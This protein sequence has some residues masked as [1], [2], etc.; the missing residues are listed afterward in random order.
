MGALKCRVFGGRNPRVPHTPPPCPF[1]CQGRESG[2]A[3]RQQNRCIAASATYPPLPLRFRGGQNIWATTGVLALGCAGSSSPPAP[4]QLRWRGET[5]AVRG[6]VPMRRKPRWLGCSVRPLSRSGRG[7]Q[8][9]EDQQRIRTP[10]RTRST[11]MSQPGAIGFEMGSC[12]S[13]TRNF[14]T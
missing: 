13:C 9:G 14:C 12:S 8:G 3:A 2:V 5:R 7:G 4:L 11:A 1:S 10:Y 6:G